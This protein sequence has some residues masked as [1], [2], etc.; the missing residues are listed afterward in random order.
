MCIKIDTVFYDYW[1]IICTSPLDIINKEINEVFDNCEKHKTNIIWNQFPNP[2]DRVLKNRPITLFVSSSKI[3]SK[4][5][6]F[7]SG[8]KIPFK[9]K[10]E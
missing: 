9:R 6:L 7:F 5:N 4:D 1:D 8:F 2:G 3:Q 10:G